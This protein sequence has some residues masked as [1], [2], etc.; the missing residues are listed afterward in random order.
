MYEQKGDEWIAM[1]VGLS[2]EMTA[3][4]TESGK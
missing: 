2:T 3:A 4:M 1:I